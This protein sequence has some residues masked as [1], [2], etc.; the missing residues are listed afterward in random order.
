VCYDALMKATFLIYAITLAMGSVLFA[1]S[2]PT[3][4]AKVHVGSDG[5]VHVVD[6]L[7]KDRTIQKEKNQAAVSAP[8]LSADRQ[9]AGWLIEQ[10][11]CC[12]SYTIPTSLAIYRAGKMRLLGD[13]LM[14]Y[15]WCFVGEGAQVA[16]STGTVHGMT[17]RH[18][19][20]YDIRS[21]RL[22]QE[23]N[24]DTDAASPIWAKDLKQ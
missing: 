9:T 15:D 21:G 20:L 22:L 4:L 16:L 10:E 2:K 17:S 11:N 8:K 13:G 12:T 24:G 6:D 18:L 5:L 19:S 14:I 7:G 3:T 1:Q 23:W